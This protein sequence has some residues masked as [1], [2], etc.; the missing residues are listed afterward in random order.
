MEIFIKFVLS[1]VILGHISKP[2]EAFIELLLLLL[3]FLL[4]LKFKLIIL[5][6]IFIGY[7]L[8]YAD[9]NL[10]FA[11]V[12]VLCLC[13]IKKLKPIICKSLPHLVCCI[14]VHIN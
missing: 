6:S 13:V 14:V 10:M 1:V 12:C 4:T 7:Y 3:F 11:S 8:K 9:L 5:T 2:L